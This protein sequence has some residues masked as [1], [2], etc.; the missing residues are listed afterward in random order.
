M[1]VCG[2]LFVV[3]FV[4]VVWMYLSVSEED[5]VECE[6]VMVENWSGMK[7]VEC[8]KVLTSE[9]AEAFERAVR[10][11]KY[12]KLCLCGSVLSLNGVVFE[13]CGMLLMVFLDEVL[14]VDVEKKL[15]RV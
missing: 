15:L 6:W 14:E 2:V 3:V 4:Y 1:F 7:W 10:S 12:W 13:E 9:S 11:G 5:D 8:E